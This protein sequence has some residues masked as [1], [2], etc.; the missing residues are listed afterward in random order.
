MVLAEFGWYGGGLPAR[1]NP[2]FAVATEEQQA[3]WCRQVVETSA[4]LA[5]GWLC[6]GFYDIPESTDCS[7]FSGM[8]TADGKT[9][10]W[11]REFQKLSAKYVGRHIPPAQLSARPTLDWNACITNLKVIDQ[12]R[13]EYIRAFA[14]AQKK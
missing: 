7:Q 11:G 13:E 5:G 4:G 14:A 2:K 8:I 10:A 3:R 9:K 1:F 12:F 6:W